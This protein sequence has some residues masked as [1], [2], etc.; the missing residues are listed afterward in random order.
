M[1][2]AAV[3]WSAHGKP[4]SQPAA[5][6][7]SCCSTARREEGSIGKIPRSKDAAFE[8]G[9]LNLIPGDSVQIALFSLGAWKH[10]ETPHIEM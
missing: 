3:S 5:G 9:G 7:A 10:T 2:L 6:I 1:H 8:R 4:V